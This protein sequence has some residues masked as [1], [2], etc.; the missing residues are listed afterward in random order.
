MLPAAYE[1]ETSLNSTRLCMPQ[2]IGSS[3]WLT[4]SGRS[5]TSNTRSNETSEVANS[6]RALDSP[7]TGH[8]AG[9]DSGKR[10]ERAFSER[11]VDD[12]DAAS[13][14]DGGG[15]DGTG[16]AECHEEPAAND[17]LADTEISNAAGVAFESRLLVLA[18]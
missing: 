14:E 8:R 17:R 11:A 16:E 12:H 9:R 15:A 4:S 10:N 18:P 6:T 1:N 7:T 13:P 2:T 3:G 5:S